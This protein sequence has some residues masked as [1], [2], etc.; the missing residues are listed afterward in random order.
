MRSSPRRDST[1]TPLNGLEFADDF[2]GAALDPGSWAA[3]TRPGN[4]AAGEYQYDHPS[5]VGVAGVSWVTARVDASVPGYGYSGGLVQWPTFSYPYGTAEIRAKLTGGAG[6]LPT[7]RLLGANCQAANL[8]VAGTVRR[9][10]G[11]SRGPARSPWRRSCSNNPF[12]VNQGIHSGAD[13]RT[14]AGH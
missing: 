3:V 13:C 1:F 10:T 11:R 4:G 8:P 12:F 14:P 6:P 7:F 5:N 2:N 9:A